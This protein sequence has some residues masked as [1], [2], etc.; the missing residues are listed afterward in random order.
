MKKGSWRE[1]IFKKSLDIEFFRKP[2]K[3]CEQ[4]VDNS[5]ATS[6]NPLKLNHYLC[7]EECDC[8]QVR[9]PGTKMPA[10]FPTCS[11]TAAA[12]VSERSFQA[13]AGKRK[14]PTQER[15]V[16]RIS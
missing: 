10:K 8:R 16:F 9:S 5:A 7:R 15:R 14:N 1:I 6:A 13:I 4:A 3:R 2:A 12:V 11:K